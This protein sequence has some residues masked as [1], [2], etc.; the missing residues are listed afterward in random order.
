MASTELQ[1]GIEHLAGCLALSRSA[2]WNQNEADWRLMLGFGHGWGISTADGTLAASTLA[3]PY[4][5][6]FAWLAMVLVLPGQRRQGYASRLL[7]VA[8]AEMQ[9][10]R[11]VV[12][13]DAT[14]AGHQVYI[15]EGFRDYWSFK[16]FALK[17]GI[18]VSRENEIRELEARDWEAVLSLDAVA[19]GGSRDV[20]LRNLAAR[21]PDAALVAERKGE[22]GGFVLAREGHEAMQIGP[23]VARHEMTA[24]ALFAAA[25]GGVSGPVYADIADHA[26]P[27]QDWAL[28]QG[29]TIQRPFTRMAHGPKGYA[30]GDASLVFC[31]A[32]AELG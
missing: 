31:P 32:G 30:P 10:Q 29:F 22:I 8:L 9:A 21:R 19:F 17:S 5:R 24:R 16:R 23:L 4:G 18:S 25:L 6:D 12:L 27:L 14:P 13:L 7:R 28:E 26:A 15:Q 3:L 11:R 20:V 1:L 2:N